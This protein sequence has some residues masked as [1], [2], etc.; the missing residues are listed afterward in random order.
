M[1]YGTCATAAATQAKVVACT[2]ATSLYSGLAIEVKF[3]YANTY[4]SGATTLNV[5]SLGAKSIYT[6]SGVTVTSSTNQIIWAAGATIMFVYN[7]TGWVCQEPNTLYGTCSTA[8]A[9]AAK[10]V[11]SAGAVI[12]KGTT[13]A[14]KFTYANTAS[15]PTLTVASTVADSI[16]I[17]GSTGIGPYWIAGQ[18]VNFTWGGSAWYESSSPVYAST[19][20]VGNEAAE[21]VYIDSDGVNCRSGTTVNSYFG[22]STVR[23]AEQAFQ[24]A[25]DEDSLAATVTNYSGGALKSS[26]SGTSIS[27]GDIYMPGCTA[28]HTASQTISSTSDTVITMG[29]YA[30]S[31]SYLYR[32]GNYVRKSATA[33]MTPNCHVSGY[34]TFYNT[35]SSTSYNACLSLY[36]GTSSTSMAAIVEAVETIPA[37]S[38]ATISIPP[39]CQASTDTYYCLK[40]H[41]TSGASMTIAAN[42]AAITVTY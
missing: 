20:T 34:A 12:V 22:A 31:S 35:S 9:T 4:V 1:L 33:S 27:G 10:A 8:A 29:G 21:N 5:N 15:T 25:Y 7:G 6:Q 24:I 14:V 36:S 2:D 26:A 32:S 13:I 17:N 19:A 30:G 3:T 23:L 38:Y 41:V 16:Y 18:T 42:E 39:V 40:A 37:Y 28:L 11:T